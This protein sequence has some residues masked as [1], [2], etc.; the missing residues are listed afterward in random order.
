MKVGQ[1][2]PAKVSLGARVQVT[3]AVPVEAERAGR[4][5]ATA[6]DGRKGVQSVE[7]AFA[8]LREL[9]G[10]QTPLTLGDLAQRTGLQPSK[11]HHYL[12]S[13]LRTGAAAQDAAGRYGL[14]P[15][16][17]QL[18]LAALNRLD[19]VERSVEA[20]HAFR[21]DTGEAAFV[22]VWGNMGPTI[23]RYV[24]GARP[25]TVEARAGLV[26]PLLTSATGHAFLTWLPEAQWRPLAALER[27]AE[28]TPG[29][30]RRDP[31]GIRDRTAERGIATVQGD[32]LP[33][34][35]A[36]SVPVFAHDGRLA[37]VLTTL[38]WRGEMD[39]ARDGP[40][41]A[42]LHAAGRDLSRSLG[43]RVAYPALTGGRAGAAADLTAPA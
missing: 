23:V 27:A 10:A 31:G 37:C 30:P 25:V 11:V 18:G 26:L 1:Q 19:V 6:A 38:G 8:V 7:I 33:R 42:R 12:V 24:E 9:E 28:A 43:S 41:A 20:A 29:T 34:I 14:G 40:V 4:H 21:D 39:V 15:Y 5:G 35:A 32:L 22:A 16:A 36:L 13:L 17:L 2:L 3:P